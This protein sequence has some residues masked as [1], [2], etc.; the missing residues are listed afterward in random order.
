MFNR[1]SLLAIIFTLTLGLSSHGQVVINEVY[2]NAVIN[3][4][5]NSPDTGEWVEFY[6]TA[7]AS[8]DMSCWVFCDGDFCVTI[9][10]GTILLAGDFF[11]VGSAVGAGCGVGCDFS[12][13]PDLDWA[14][15]GC[16]AGTSVGVLTNGGEQIVLYDDSGTVIDAVYWSGGQSLPDNI[17][18]ISVAVGVCASQTLTLPATTDAIYENIG[19]A[20]GNGQSKARTTNGG[21]TWSNE[22]NPSAGGSNAP[23]PITL[24]SFEASSERNLVRFTWTTSSE[25]NNDYFT[26]E[27]SVDGSIFTPLLTISG[28][29]NST[30][31]IDYEAVDQ[32]PVFGKSYYRLKQTDFDGSSETFDIVAVNRSGFGKITVYPNPTSQYDDL[33]IS[34]PGNKDQSAS[35]QLYNTQGKRVFAEKIIEAHQHNEIRIPAQMN[36]GIYIVKV[37]SNGFNLSQ[38][39]IVLK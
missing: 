17:G 9:P 32:N 33:V 19:S 6:N 18:N 4:G 25:L 15:C 29:G 37:S 24:R 36:P 39:L 2:I 30:I 22:G 5:A 3:D 23:L 26:I 12:F 11:L 1:K 7:A 31:A 16:T 28:V 38:Q 20:G 34:F 10:D 8:V 14:T 27:R 13:T 35:I 21:S